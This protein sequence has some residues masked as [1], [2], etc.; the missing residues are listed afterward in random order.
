MSRSGARSGL[1]AVGVLF[2]IAVIVGMLGLWRGWWG[3]SLAT[4]KANDETEMHV[5]IDKGQMKDDADAVLD[6]TREA[7]ETAKVAVEMETVRGTIADIDYDTRQFG[8]QTESGTLDFT[9]G[10]ATQLEAGESD[11][12]FA[13]LREGD[14]VLVTYRDR[15]GTSDVLNVEVLK[16]GE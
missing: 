16:S 12:A 2:V 10:S 1:R 9:W 15:A 6:R 13:A 5:T 3:I 4:D 8:L 7:Q 14:E 11:T